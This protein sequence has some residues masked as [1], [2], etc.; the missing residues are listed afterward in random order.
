[1]GNF[2]DADSPGVSVIKQSQYIH[3]CLARQCLSDTLWK[4]AKTKSQKKS[5][6]KKTKKKNQ[7]KNKKKNKKKKK[8]K[9]KKRAKKKTT[10]TRKYN[11]TICH[12]VK[13]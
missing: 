13:S 10:T 9:P 12:K 1:M 8:K 11:Q 5:Q 7:K 3:K 6:K 2:S 4:K